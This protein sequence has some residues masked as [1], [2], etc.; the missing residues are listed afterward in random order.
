[1]KKK[2]LGTQLPDE[3]QAALAPLGKA[4]ACAVDLKIDPWEFALR[5]RHLVDL[6]V[7]KGILRWLVLHGYVTF[8]DQARCFQPG[9]N[10][11]AGGDPRFLITEAG[12][13]AMSLKRE[14][15]GWPPGRCATV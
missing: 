4:F 9:G 12:A 10:A 6:G 5:M 7:D 2:Q 15:P 13:F 14:G 1:M 3:A 8:R 11:T